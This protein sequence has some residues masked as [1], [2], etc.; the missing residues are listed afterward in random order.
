MHQGESVVQRTVMELL[1][2]ASNK[3]SQGDLLG[4]VDFYGQAVDIDPSSASAWYGLGVMQAKRGN[5]VD[6][7]AAFEKAHELNPNHGPT[8]ANLAV[9]L[10]G[11]EP[12]RASEM[13]RMALETVADQEN[14][15][16]IASMH[17]ANDEAQS[18]SEEEIE[19]VPMLEATAVEE[20]PLLHSAVVLSDIGEVVSE[21]REMLSDGAFQEALDAIQPRLEGDASTN[22]ELWSICGICLSQLGNDEEAIQAIEYAI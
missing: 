20:M 19:E 4:A 13:A 12:I 3:A 17:E 10:E 1:E 6:A 14:L 18:V 15:H 2:E 5:T 7:V 22:H 9:L 21:A 16:R 8:S 11:S